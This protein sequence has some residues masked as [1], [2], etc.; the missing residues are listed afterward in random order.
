LTKLQQQVSS[1]IGEITGMEQRLLKTMNIE[2]P[3]QFTES[4]FNQ[5]LKL[6]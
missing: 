2:E 1:G 4:L 6:E 5:D 3:K